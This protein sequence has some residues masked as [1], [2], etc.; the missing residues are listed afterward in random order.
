M[1]DAPVSGGVGGAAA[2]TL[3]FM[4]GGEND[5]LEDAKPYL[6]DMGTN[7]VHCGGAGEQ[8]L[9]KNRL[10]PFKLCFV[11]FVLSLSRLIYI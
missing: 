9:N 8:F 6:Y 5:A 1:I 11:Y 2:G 4:V 10:Y 3:T 7:V